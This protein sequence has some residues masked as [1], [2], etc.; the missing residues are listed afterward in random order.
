MQFGRDVI[1]HLKKAEK[2]E[3]FSEDERK[4]GETELQK[5]TDKGTKDIDTMLSQKEKEILEV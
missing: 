3:H 2:A 5:V 1:E 4:K